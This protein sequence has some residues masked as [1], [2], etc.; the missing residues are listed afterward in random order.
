MSVEDVFIFISVLW[1]L[2]CRV[3]FEA[4]KNLEFLTVITLN[5][6]KLQLQK[7]RTHC[8]QTEVSHFRRENVT[9]V[10][11]KTSF[12]GTLLHNEIFSHYIKWWC[13]VAPFG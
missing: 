1:Q 13:G 4:R 3:G 9:Q 6:R 12:F 5:C 8:T 7:L 10:A 11:N 2:W